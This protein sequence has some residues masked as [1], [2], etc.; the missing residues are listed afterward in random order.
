MEFLSKSL[1]FSEIIFCK[2]ITSLAFEFHWDG[3]EFRVQCVW[4]T[5][6]IHRG[7]TVIQF[8]EFKKN[9]SQIEDLKLSW[10][11]RGI[12]LFCLTNIFSL[13]TKRNCAVFKNEVLKRCK[14]KNKNCPFKNNLYLNC[15]SSNN[16]SFWHVFFYQWLLG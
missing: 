12:F 10:D 2:R 4:Y 3:G 16:S 14:E 9:C 13:S 11:S 6:N 7:Y 15:S 1:E 8:W 5:Y